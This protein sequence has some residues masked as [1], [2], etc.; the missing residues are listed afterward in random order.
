MQARSPAP[1]YTWSQEEGSISVTVNIPSLKTS[2]ELKNS[3]IDTQSGVIQFGLNG[4][5]PVIQGK[6]YGKIMDSLW[7]VCGTNVTIELE[8]DPMEFWPVL[9][10]DKVGGKM[11]AQS[12]Y[13][14]G[15]YQENFL[16]NPGSAFKLFEEAATK[17]SLD[18]HFKLFEIYSDPGQQSRFQVENDRLKAFTHLK[19]AAD[20]GNEQ[21]AFYVGKLYQT[22]KDFPV[23]PN[24]PLAF[25]Y[26]QKYSDKNEMCKYELAC[27]YFE[28]KGIQ[29]NLATALFWFQQVNVPLPQVGYHVGQI[30]F[31]G[32]EGYSTRNIKLAIESWNQAFE[33]GSAQAAYSLGE[34]Y[35][36]GDD[37]VEPDIF[38]ASH[39]FQRAK[40][41]DPS[42]EPPA[43]LAEAQKNYDKKTQRGKKGQKRGQK[44][45]MESDWSG[46]AWAGLAVA[47]VGVGAAAVYFMRNKQ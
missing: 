23:E 4:A 35:L 7:S 17:D 22:P 16:Q 38:S 45:E 28:G 33:L 8:K 44:S 14:L 6:L 18:A 40:E 42:L 47:A 2:K 32:P 43:A 36:K 34:L 39:Y 15:I 30:Y 27:C 19:A 10:I 13:N 41:L 12:L 5:T 1:A 29:K 46:L 9:I 11:D 21:A 25:S 37:G 26:F 31:E 20:L 3:I 24:L